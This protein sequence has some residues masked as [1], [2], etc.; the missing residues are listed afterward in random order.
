MTVSRLPRF[1]IFALLVATALPACSSAADAPGIHMM[2]ISELPAE[3][4]SA[5]ASVRA[6]YQFAAANPDLMVNV[7]SDWGP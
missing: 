4:Q 6:A 5:P 3:I 2:P 7:L 1:V